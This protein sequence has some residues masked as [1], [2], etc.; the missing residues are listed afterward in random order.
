M[1]KLNLVVEGKRPEKAELGL[2]NN[3]EVLRESLYA[4]FKKVLCRDDISL[5]ILMGDGKHSAAKFFVEKSL[6]DQ[7]S[8]SA[9]F[10]DSDL[11]PAKSASWFDNFINKVN[12]EKSIIIPDKNKQYVFFMVQEMEAWFLKQLVCL[13]KWAEDEGYRYKPVIKRRLQIDI[14][15]HTVIKNRKIEDISKPSEKLSLLMKTYYKD[16]DNKAAKYG[17]LA[18][19]PI[20]LNYLDIPLLLEQDSELK[21]FR[22]TY[23]NC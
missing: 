7:Q 2:V 20:L 10:M 6:Q 13:E 16:M 18:T 23:L 19:A 12:P 17:K 4:F 22:A 3:A 21:R 8:Q 15:E 11:P 5:T 14:T 9:L 1:V